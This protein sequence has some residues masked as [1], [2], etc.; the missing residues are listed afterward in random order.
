ML[1]SKKSRFEKKACINFC[2]SMGKEF[3]ELAK[4]AEKK[5]RLR[6]VVKRCSLEEKSRLKR[7]KISVRIRDLCSRHQKA[8]TVPQ[9]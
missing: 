2:D 9:Q 3:L 6:V 8:K 5:R 4:M 7:P 1:T